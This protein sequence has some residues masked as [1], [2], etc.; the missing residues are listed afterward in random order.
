MRNLSASR[1]FQGFERSLGPSRMPPVKPSVH[2]GSNRGEKRRLRGLRRVLA[3]KAMSPGRR[4]LLAAPTFLAKRERGSLGVASSP[5]TTPHPLGE[6]CEIP[7]SRTSSGIT[8][9]MGRRS[10]TFGT[11]PFRSR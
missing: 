11:G 2:A 10:E 6:N 4:F 1:L 7:S 9:T 3:A 8:R 5:S